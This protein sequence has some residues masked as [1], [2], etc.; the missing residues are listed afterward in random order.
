MINHSVEEVFSLQSLLSTFSTRGEYQLKAKTIDSPLGSMI[1]I[2]DHEKLYFLS[3]SDQPNLAKEIQTIAKKNRATIQAGQS[4][5]I[6]SI[7]DELK[8]YFSGQ[9]STFETPIHC[10]GT[11]FQ[12]KAWQALKDIPFGQTRSYQEQAKAIGNEKAF[13]AVANANGAN[14]LT[15][16]LPCHR[17]INHNGKLGGYKNGLDRKSWLLQHEKKTLTTA[18]S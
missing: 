10:V 6:D 2:A 13:R 9:L 8:K 18:F 12:H 4:S 3:Y 5:V 14:H 15:I 11:D 1:A 7:E 17:I 16:V